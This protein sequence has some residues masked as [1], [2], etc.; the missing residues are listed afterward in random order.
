[1]KTLRRKAVDLDI[2]IANDRFVVIVERSETKQKVVGV[3]AY[4]PRPF[5]ITK[6]RLPVHDCRCPKVMPAKIKGIC[7]CIDWSRSGELIFRP[8]KGK[9][10]DFALIGSLFHAKAEPFHRIEPCVAVRHPHDESRLK[11]FRR[12]M[13]NFKLSPE[14]LTILKPIGTSGTVFPAGRKAF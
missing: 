1:M 13:N 11:I 7:S 4:D 14:R 9:R 2:S 10:G 3:D 12:G 8:G 6:N 5:D